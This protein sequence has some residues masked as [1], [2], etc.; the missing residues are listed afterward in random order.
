MS[1]LETL[2]AAGA[3]RRRRGR[4][5]LLRLSHPGRHLDEAQQ[6]EVLLA[7]AR[8]T[9][10][11][12]QADTTFHW[13]SRKDYFSGIRHLWVAFLGTEPVGFTSVRTHSGA[14]EKIIYIDNLNIRSVPLRVFDEH[15]IGSMLVYEILLANYPIRRDVSVVFR[16]Q[17]PSVYRLAYAI[18]PVA[19]YPRINRRPARNEIRSRRILAHMAERLSPGKL[20][21]PDASIIRSAYGGHIYGRP[22]NAPQS[23]KPALARFWQQ[24]VCLE[25]GDAVLIASCATRVEVRGLVHHYLRGLGRHILRRIFGLE[26]RG[27]KS[28]STTASDAAA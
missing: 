2:L 21:E 8:E 24:H 13:L 4:F 28:S 10:Q 15:T 22:P 3:R 17:N 26:G 27:S 11:I 20:Y 6:R 14:G 1:L 25:K 16:T 9:D 12:Y 7:F 19:V 5:H 18:S 23:V